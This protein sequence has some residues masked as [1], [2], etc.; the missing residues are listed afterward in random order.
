MSKLGSFSMTEKVL[1]FIKK[2]EENIEKKRR[3]FERI[4]FQNFLGAYTVLDNQGTNYPITLIDISKEG[5]LFQVPWDVNG[6]SEELAKDEPMTLRMYFTKSSY[7]PVQVEVKYG[8]EFV[9]TD[10]QTYMRYGCEFDK[11][12][13]SFQAMES[14]IDFLY[15][16]AEHSS[17]DK[18]DTKAFFY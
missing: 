17:F 12:F 1:D 3:T 2:R 6:G 13:P 4:L 11:T 7:I 18:G 16:F 15:S 5:C 10:G 8:K 9:D 14:F